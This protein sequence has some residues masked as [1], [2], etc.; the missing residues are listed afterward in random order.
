[1][2]ARARLGVREALACRIGTPCVGAAR[3]GSEGNGRAC[4]AGTAARRG[5]GR[6]ATFGADW[7]STPAAVRDRRRGVGCGV[8]T[9]N[10]PPP[11]DIDIGLCVV[12]V[13]ALPLPLGAPG[14]RSVSR[15]GGFLKG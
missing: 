3:V 12:S 7:P 11:P 9:S 5:A 15:A 2:G 4:R 13:L 6:G 14:S 10:V 8:S 1:M